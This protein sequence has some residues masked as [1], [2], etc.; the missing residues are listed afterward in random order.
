MEFHQSGKAQGFVNVHEIL[1]NR[2]KHSIE[3]IIK[4]IDELSEYE[5]EIK[6][7]KQQIII[8]TDMDIM[9]TLIERARAT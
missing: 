3:E 9:S 5:K 7:L 2:H 4:T 6:K 8:A 1:D